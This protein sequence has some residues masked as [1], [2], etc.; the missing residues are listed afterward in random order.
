M[1]L[2]LLV[3]Y[4]P[5]K[6]IKFQYPQT[7]FS[8]TITTDFEALLENYKIQGSIF[9]LIH[10]ACNFSTSVLSTCLKTS[11]TVST[12]MLVIGIE[13][14]IL[15]GIFKI[16]GIEIID[17]ADTILCSSHGNFYSTIMKIKML[18][19]LMGS[20]LGGIKFFHGN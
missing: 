14:A 10:G 20:T 3:R 8:K 6:E 18:S 13:C 15:S 12:I 1:K 17:P 11:L 19:L 7:H 2:Y 9:N 5:I 16:T 4:D